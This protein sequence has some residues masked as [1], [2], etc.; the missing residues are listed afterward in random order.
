VFSD[1]I[2]SGHSL[3]R[4]TGIFTVEIGKETVGLPE[5]RGFSPTAREARLWRRADALAVQFPEQAAILGE[6]RRKIGLLEL[7]QQ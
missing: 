1:R 4:R 6:N 7:T 5:E 3:H 2:S